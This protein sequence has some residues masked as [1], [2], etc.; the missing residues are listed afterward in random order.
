MTREPLRGEF[1]TVEDFLG[2]RRPKAWSFKVKEAATSRREERANLEAR[3]EHLRT[4]PGLWCSA[5][6]KPAKEGRNLRRVCPAGCGTLA[7][8]G[9]WDAYF[10][11]DEGQARAIRGE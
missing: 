1:E 6:G 11:E 7:V 3:R 8:D 9:V 10:V 5:C 2:D 4:V